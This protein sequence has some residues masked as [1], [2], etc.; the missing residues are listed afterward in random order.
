MMHA[1]NRQSGF[2]LVEIVIATAISGIAIAVVTLLAIDVTGFS[3]SLG[4][5]IEQEQ[6]LAPFLRL[7]V[8]E[9]RSIGPAENGAY[10]IAQASAQTFT[11]FA[12]VD[13]DGTFEQVRYFVSG[14]TLK[15][16]VIEPTATEPIQYPPANETVTDVVTGLVPGTVFTYYNEG[17]PPVATPLPSPVNVT[18][19]RLVTATLTV[20]K[21]PAA[22]PGPSTLSVSATIRNLR[23]DI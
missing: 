12:D 18:D 20:D 21:D 10:H 17:Y 3:T 1:P 7:L 8:S 23:G 11:F 13:N 6:E 19:V 2:T 4:S 9:I 5:R 22:E 16:G 14:T 15:K